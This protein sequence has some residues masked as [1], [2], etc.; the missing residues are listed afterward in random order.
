MRINAKDVDYRPCLAQDDVEIYFPAGEYIIRQPEV[1]D[2][3]DPEWL[4]RSMGMAA[5]KVTGNVRIIGD[6]PTVTRLKFVGPNGEDPA[7]WC[8]TL[9]DKYGVFRGPGFRVTGSLRL[10]N[11]TLDGGCN[12][13]GDHRWPTAEGWDLSHKCI[14]M[15]QGSLEVWNCVLKRWRGEIVYGGGQWPNQV[16]LKNVVIQE[17][18]ASAVAVSGNVLVE[19]CYFYRCY[20]GM[21]QYHHLGQSTSVSHSHFQDCWAHGIAHEKGTLHVRRCLFEGA[22][23]GIYTK[24]GMYLEVA[25]SVL[26]GQKTPI[27]TAGCHTLDVARCRIKG[28][29]AISL[30]NYASETE[31]MTIQQ[32]EIMGGV[33]IE[34]AC[35]NRQRFVVDG[36][37]FATN[38]IYVARKAQRGLWTNNTYAYAKEFWR[39]FKAETDRHDF[40]AGTYEIKPMRE[41]Y[42]V[43]LLGGGTLVLTG[44]TD[45]RVRRYGSLAGTIT[46]NG[47]LVT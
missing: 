38:T 39:H 17:T 5:L 45:C 4:K 31:R 46:Y 34:D 3:S 27:Y 7:S 23:R 6:G 10:E 2:L 8:M 35:S 30:N 42:A 43:Q 11:L 40:Q 18:N 14:N 33:G 24:D 12:A 36:N 9:P 20:N 47:A 37:A 44:P 15:T 16:R 19:E 22:N 32:C 41:E 25:D 21:E 13:T 29:T 1:P 28:D 26:L